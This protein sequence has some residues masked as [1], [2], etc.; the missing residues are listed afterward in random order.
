MSWRPAIGHAVAGQPGQAATA[1]LLGTAASYGI[2]ISAFGTF[3]CHTKETMRSD[4]DRLMIDRQVDALV[5]LNGD[6]MVSC[7]AAFAYMNGGADM[8]GL[9]VKRPGERPILLYHPMEQHQA[10]RTGLELVSLSRWNR[11]AFLADHGGDQL[12]GSAAHLWSILHDVGV[13][14]SVA[15]CG[16]DEVGATYSL[17]RA[18]ENL[19]GI[20]VVGEFDQGILARARLTKDPDEAGAIV[21]TSA[22][23]SEVVLA[24]Y[25]LLRSCRVDDLGGL[26]DADG[27]PLNVSAVKAFVRGE[28][29]SRDLEAPEGFIF[30]L[31]SDAGFPHSAGRPDDVLRTGIPIVF[32]IFPR[33]HGGYY[34]DVTRTFCLGHATGPVVEA[35]SQLLDVFERVMGALQ[36]GELASTYQEMTCDMLETLGHSTSRTDYAATEGYTSSLGHGVGLEI[37]EEPF[38]ASIPG[39]SDRL[40]PGSV[41]TIE[42]GLYYPSRGFGM[43]IED[44]VYCDSRGLFQR[45]TALPYDLVLP[46]EGG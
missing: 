23:A 46:M 40:D 3:G 13:A 44:T 8:R 7:N 4:I 24:T 26:L 31:G 35:Y 5:V 14:G 42:P 36:A 17:W 43:R 16:V 12:A 2:M 37:H 25:Q 21:S 10:E 22:L 11:K 20:E 1:G 27:R 6:G 28:L 41:F 38:I 15:F 32:D 19:G 29:A 9:V 34:T 18:L 33:T 45:L 39:R 30:A